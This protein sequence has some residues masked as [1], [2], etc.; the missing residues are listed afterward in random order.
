MAACRRCRGTKYRVL[1]VDDHPRARD[2]L[3]TI[4]GLNDGTL[5]QVLGRSEA[6]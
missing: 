6:S 1:V 3:A 5:D 4:I 2:M